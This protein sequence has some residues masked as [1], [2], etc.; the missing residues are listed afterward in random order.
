[1]QGFTTD[2]RSKQATECNLRAPAQAN[3]LQKAIPQTVTLGGNRV[4]IVFY[5]A[6]SLRPRSPGP[7]YNAEAARA[8]PTFEVEQPLTCS[9]H[10]TK[11]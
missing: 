6:S 9:W 8:P 11:T 4:R 5:D 10:A 3:P 1:M 7:S 2:T